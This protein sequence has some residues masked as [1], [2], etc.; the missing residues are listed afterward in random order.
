[1]SE[2]A[3]YSSDDR[4]ILCAWHTIPDSYLKRVFSPENARDAKDLIRWCLKGKPSDRPEIKEILAHPFCNPSEAIT[5]HRLMKYHAFLSHA[6]GDASG[7]AATLY[8]LHKNLGIHLWYDMRANQL[9]LDGMK[10]GVKDSDVILIVLTRTTLSR[11][12]CRQEILEAIAQDRHIQLILEEDPRFNP[13]DLDLWKKPKW[14]MIAII[15]HS[16]RQR[17]SGQ[18]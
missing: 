9:N 11:W 18:Q 12:F 13:F 2:K 17:Q 3:L 15:N 7:T 6:Q 5:S 1:M 8:S 16:T 10:Q 14:Y 4:T